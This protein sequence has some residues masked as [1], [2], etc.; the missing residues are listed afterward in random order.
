MLSSSDAD[1][2]N[3]AARAL[4]AMHAPDAAARL[5]DAYRRREHPQLSE[6]H[7]ARLGKASPVPAGVLP[8]LDEVRHFERGAL[9]RAL[10]RR[11]LPDAEALV[12]ATFDDWELAMV[13]GPATI[14]SVAGWRDPELLRTVLSRPIPEAP[15]ALPFAAYEL[16]SLAARHLALAGD[17]DALALLCAWATDRSAERAADAA[18]HLALL[19]HPAGVAPVARLL[20]GRSTRALEL[21]LD[22]AER[23]RTPLL[24]SALAAAAARRGRREEVVTTLSW[25]VDPE[26]A[27]RRFD[28]PLAELEAL[29]GR[30]DPALRYAAHARDARRRARRSQ[31]RSAQRRGPQPARNHGRGPRIRSRG[32][33]RRQPGR[34]RRLASA[35]TR[36]RADRGGRLGVPRCGRAAAGDRSMTT[37]VAAALSSVVATRCAL[38]IR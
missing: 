2:G 30:L 7:L 3:A 23:Y 26:T 28:P 14:D 20:R 37:A 6:G 35:R 1:T 12:E 16:R 17:A 19:A 13:V 18:L 8:R 25:I 38:A 24:A 31:R 15:P 34:D 9:M 27:S 10:L 22:A 11:R 29:A 36:R 21:A 33:S 4:S 5:A 32:R